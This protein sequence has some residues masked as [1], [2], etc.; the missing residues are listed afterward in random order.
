MEEGKGLN[1]RPGGGGAPVNHGGQRTRRH[2]SDQGRTVNELTSGGGRYL[3]RARAVQIGRGLEIP[4]VGPSWLVVGQARELGSP[5]GE[6]G[7]P[8]GAAA[9][10]GG[11][12][13]PVDGAGYLAASSLQDKLGPI[14][15]P[16]QGDWPAG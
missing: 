8:D 7:K 15:W 12:C 16:G 2:G 5:Y 4:G 13:P 14:S 10:L 6:A 11:E 9:G 3:D 1:R